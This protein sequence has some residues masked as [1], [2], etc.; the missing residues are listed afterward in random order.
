[1]NRS[2]NVHIRS[3][4]VEALDQRQLLTALV[5]FDM[6]SNTGKAASQ[7][8]TSVTGVTTSTLTRGGTNFAPASS[9]I[10][11]TGTFYGSPQQSNGQYSS[12]QS[13]A[14]TKQHYF[15][16]TA[17]PAAGKTIAVTGIDVAAFGQTNKK[18]NLGIDYSTDGGST[19]TT[20]WT[21]STT[22]SGTPNVLISAP[23]TVAATAS[24]IIFRVIT[25]SDMRTSSPIVPDRYFE[26]T[27][28]G[29]H[30][31]ADLI[32][33]GTVADALPAAPSNLV[34]GP[35]TQAL[36]NK[37]TWADNA[38][39]ETGFTVERSESSTF[40]GTPT[41]FSVAANATAFEDTTAVLGT[42]YYYRVRANNVAG[43]SANS[44]SVHGR[45]IHLYEGWGQQTW[46]SEFTAPGTIRPSAN[47]Y[48]NDIITLYA[49]AYP[50]YGIWEQIDGH[51]W[52]PDVGNFD[53]DNIH[54]AVNDL[55]A[56]GIMPED[57]EDPY[58]MWVMESPEAIEASIAVHK[59]LATIARAAN[60][61]VKLGMYAFPVYF[62][63]FDGPTTAAWESL[64]NHVIEELFQPGVYYDFSAVPIY[65]NGDNFANDV[66]QQEV[67]IDIL[68]NN[69]VEMIPF[70]SERALS[71]TQRDLTSSEI[72]TMAGLIAETGY[73]GVRWDNPDQVWTTARSAL[74]DQLVSDLF[75]S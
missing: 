75:N 16:F 23:F 68:K 9:E 5:S 33:Q 41:T 55:P 25:W 13:G 62:S 10:T 69:G 31:G 4:I 65:A 38:T 11:Q 74:Q 73:S 72:T 35:D 24:P 36:G 1:M 32:L 46:R 42:K 6:A 66:A 12:T 52:T 19:F 21:G 64:A 22:S 34:A 50:P 18:V 44:N 60:P 27:S 59:E 56:G 48:D 47:D 29:W 45:T 26:R 40:A 15:T 53:E 43:S 57:I 70:F 58:S 51:E 67:L 54:Q 63:W 17:T 30:S 61:N 2:P 20:G 71:G 39:N 14:V 3:A 28:I 37:L 7:A 8:G 49:N